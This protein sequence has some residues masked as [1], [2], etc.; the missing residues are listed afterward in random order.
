MPS[1]FDWIEG[2][3]GTQQR[4]VSQP[5]PEGQTVQPPAFSLGTVSILKQ[6]KGMICR[7]PYLEAQG[8][9]SYS[10]PIPTDDPKAA[11]DALIRKQSRQYC[12]LCF[13]KD[14]A[15]F[16]IDVPLFKPLG[17]RRYTGVR[18]RKIG[19]E[20]SDEAIFR[21]LIATCY[22]YQGAWKKWLPF[23]GITGVEEVYF[24]FAGRVEECGPSPIRMRTVDI[25]KIQ[26]D[27]DAI[28]A[29]QPSKVEVEFGDACTDMWHNDQCPVRMEVL[30]EPC[31]ID[32]ISDARRRKRRLNRLDDLTNCA[33]RPFEANGKRT[34]E[35]MAI[36]TCIYNFGEVKP[37]DQIRG[38][39]YTL[40]WQKD[41]FRSVLPRSIAW[42]LV[43]ITITWL[44]V[45]VWDETKGGWSTAMGFGQ[46]V[47]ACIMLVLAYT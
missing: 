38:I 4:S 24:E 43:G 16:A 6:C 44:S 3:L 33:K 26:E 21:K 22:Q 31:I 5:D 27:M 2:G 46:L 37:T 13:E 41:R 20:E 19:T 39:K 12:F 8:N 30:S 18:P 40:G 47:A 42:A 28:I 15:Q 34:L 14:Q 36:D 32:R 23:Y 17:P 45:I 7:P 11:M 35:G 1:S 29:M 9:E 10:A 25:S